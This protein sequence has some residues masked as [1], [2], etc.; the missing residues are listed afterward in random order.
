MLDTSGDPVSTGDYRGRNHLFRGAES[1]QRALREHSEL[2]TGPDREID[3]VDGDH[4]DGAGF[5][6]EVS[7]GVNHRELPF[8]IKRAGGLVK[9]QKLRVPYGD[10]SKANHLTLS[11]RQPIHALECEMADAE[12]GE[13]VFDGLFRGWRIQRPDRAAGGQ[14]RFVSQQRAGR[15]QGLGQVTDC[16]DASLV[17]GGRQIHAVQLD[18]AGTC[19]EAGNGA[20]KR[21]FAGGVRA[22]KANQ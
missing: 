12:G 15:R 10:L 8:Q 16:L 6:Q 1:D 7:N 11:S 14:H 13:C 2:I 22:E 18:A 4:G 17:V 3:I 20:Q 9:Q 5:T 19:A 21:R